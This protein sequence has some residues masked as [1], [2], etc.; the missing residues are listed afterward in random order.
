L[1]QWKVNMDVEPLRLEAGKAAGDVLE[2]A[3]LKP[4]GC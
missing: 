2:A 1:Q 4:T 3:A